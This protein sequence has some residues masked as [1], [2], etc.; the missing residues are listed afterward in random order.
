MPIV[1]EED[2]ELDLVSDDEYFRTIAVLLNI[3]MSGTTNKGFIFDIDYYVTEDATRQ[4][5]I[6]GLRKCESFPLYVFG[7]P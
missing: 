7:K 1:S 4:E 6:W 5:L 2:K 3:D